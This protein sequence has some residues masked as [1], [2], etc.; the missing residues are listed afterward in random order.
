MAYN[1]AI[2]LNP[3]NAEFFN[4]LGITLHYQDKLEDAIAAYNKAISLN[5]DNADA[6]YNM[7]ITLNDL[8]M[9][10][11]SIM[12]YNKAILLNLGNDEV[13]NNLYYPLQ[14]I[15]F[16]RK[17]DQN[18]SALYPKKLIPIMTRSSSVF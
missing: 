2:S 14:S 1:K 3:D 11:E 16:E 10:E 9:L 6:Y 17:C 5:P 8:G 18:L 7:G 4:N 13:W 12:A 15:K